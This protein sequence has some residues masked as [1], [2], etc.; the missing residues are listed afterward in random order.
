MS[1]FTFDISSVQSALI[2]IKPG[3][4]KYQYIMGMLHKS[5]LSKDIEFQRKY[6]GFY[7]VRRND[8]FC[9]I[10]FEYM[11]QHKKDIVTFDDVISHIYKE[12]NRYEA[13]FSSKLLATINPDMPVWDS[14]VLEQLSL[15]ASLYSKKGRLPKT[16]FLYKEIVSW[17]A[18]FLETQNA[19]DIICIF[20]ELYPD[21]NLTSVK[22]I[23]FVLWGLGKEAKNKQA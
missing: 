1:M 19:D 18:N 5:D 23:D 17:Y 15:T 11:E 3:L 9:Q 22:K 16:I 7:R 12:T 20:D 4:E 14:L 13:S 6:K 21:S 2:N 8:E 10:Y